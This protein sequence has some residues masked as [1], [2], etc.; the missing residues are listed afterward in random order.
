MQNNTVLRYE[1]AS[2]GGKIDV[3]FAAVGEGDRGRGFKASFFRRCVG[4]VRP[5]PD[6]GQMGLSR[7]GNAA[8]GEGGSDFACLTQ[9]DYLTPGCFESFTN[10]GRVWIF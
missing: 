10:S 7:G 6:G 9:E 2:L 8:F 3:C 4:V 1:G 5:I